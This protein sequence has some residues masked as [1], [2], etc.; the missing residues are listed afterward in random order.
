MLTN[1]E[2]LEP[3]GGDIVSVDANL[4]RMPAGISMALPEERAGPWIVD[5]AI[6]RKLNIVLQVT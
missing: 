5:N 3:G 2:L 6:D 4:I 1:R